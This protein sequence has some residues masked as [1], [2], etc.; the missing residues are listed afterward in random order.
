MI[1][2]YYDIENGTSDFIT[3]YKHG[4]TQREVNAYVVN[5]LNGIFR[6]ISDTSQFNKLYID[7][8]TLLIFLDIVG[9]NAL[10]S[11]RNKDG[12]VIKNF[13]GYK[14]FRHTPE[15]RYISLVNDSDE[16]A[17]IYLKSQGDIR[18][19]RLNKILEK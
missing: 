14:I 7:P 2:E 19:G 6:K 9:I 12:S 5:M 11:Q 15:E 16:V 4:C 3:S 13:M 10:K 8:D 18:N 1:I 17:R